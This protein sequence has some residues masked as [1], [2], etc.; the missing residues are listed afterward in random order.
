MYVLAI[1]F[2]DVVHG[3]RVPRGRLGLLLFA[4]I[5]T[6]FILVRRRAALFVD[7]PGMGVIAA[8]DDA[9]VADDVEFLGS[10]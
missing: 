7:R 10:G 9:V 2:D 6:E 1:L 3:R 5:D 8:A 4:E